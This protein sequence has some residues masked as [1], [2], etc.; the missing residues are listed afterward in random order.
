M[1]KGCLLTRLLQNPNVQFVAFTE[2]QKWCL[3]AFSS[4]NNLRVFL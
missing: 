4:K 2:I 1:S 3:P